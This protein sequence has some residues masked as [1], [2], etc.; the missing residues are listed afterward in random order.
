MHIGLT[1]W[2][3]EAAEG[4][5]RELLAL[6]QRADEL[7]FDSLW[8]AEY[9]FRRTGLPYPS[10]LLLAAAVFARTERMRVGTGVTLVPLHHPLI[11]AEQLAQLDVQSEGRLD[12]GIGRPNDGGFLAA[13]G[14][15]PA[16][17]HERFVR[18]YDLLLRAWTE[19]RAASTDGPW[20]FAETEVGPAPVQ[21]PNPPIWVAGMS[22]ETIGF[23]VERRLPVLLSLER[24]EGLQLERWRELPKTPEQTADL[25]R[26]SLNRYVFI[27]RTDEEAQARLDQALL[28]I[29]RRRR[30]AP[31]DVDDRETV[32]TARANLIHHQAIVGT[33]DACIV[34]IER[35]AREVGTGH[36][37]CVFNALGA[38]DRATTLAQMEL[39]AEE[40][41]PACRA[42]GPL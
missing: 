39:F 12:V 23:A 6:F 40:V 14:I 28:P 26:F 32:K 37:R 38:L 9:H 30:W 41:L 7:G 24:P 25:W 17:K 3:R 13:L 29:L 35:L 18:G 5:H 34:E 4:G 20:R 19:G 22:A 8:L 15:D 27:G 10:P 21:Q 36:L 1:G 16:T 2:Q 42:I 33:P 11:L 31:V